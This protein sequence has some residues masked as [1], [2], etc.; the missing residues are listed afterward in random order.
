MSSRCDLIM[1]IGGL[2]SDKYLFDQLP[3]GTPYVRE[4]ETL[5]EPRGRSVCLGEDQRLLH[6]VE[7]TDARATA[8]FPLQV[9]VRTERSN[10]MQSAA[11]AIRLT[12]STSRG[13]PQAW[14][15]SSRDNSGT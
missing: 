13:G 15:V 12:A 14:I 4:P 2:L 10:M 8:A 1:P 5:R 11:A 3:I 7:P 6:V 9:E